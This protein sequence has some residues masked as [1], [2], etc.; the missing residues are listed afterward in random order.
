MKHRLVE[1]EEIRM[2]FL[3]DSSLVKRY[4]TYSATAEICRQLID[5][6]GT[7]ASLKLFGPELI[8]VVDESLTNYWDPVFSE[9][10]PVKLRAAVAVYAQVHGK[11]YGNW[12]QGKKALSDTP[13]NFITSWRVVFRKLK[14]LNE[15]Q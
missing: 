4:T 14:Q 13:E 8:Q 10:I 9:K 12:I 6:I 5:G 7:E 3:S 11:D 1:D 2:T 15:G